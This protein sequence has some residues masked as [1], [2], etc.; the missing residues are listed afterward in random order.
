MD[1]TLAIRANINGIRIRYYY[2]AGLR[3]GIGFK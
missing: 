2:N 1:Y 3:Y